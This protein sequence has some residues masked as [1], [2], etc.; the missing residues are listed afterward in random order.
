MADNE[1]LRAL[2]AEAREFLCDPC[3]C[4]DG[5]GEMR[6]RI[7]AALAV[8]AMPCG[9]CGHPLTEVRPGKHQCDVC[10]DLRLHK[11]DRLRL[12]VENLRLERERDEARA[13]VE[14]L[15]VQ[16]EAHET[17]HRLA[18][19][20]IRRLS[21]SFNDALHEGNKARA[22]AVSAFRRGAEAMREAAAKEVFA[23][24][25]WSKD[26]EATR[27]D[28]KNLA[29]MIDALPVPGATCKVCKRHDQ[30]HDP[31]DCADGG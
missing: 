12:R 7:D 22:E 3:I 20:E 29:E 6:F 21:A 23:F 19:G 10:D 13:E 24:Y 30:P 2:L 17:R 4:D 31:C 28:I 1:K 27:T 14:R 5:V 9:D 16:I 26:N 25:A 11:E 15:K 8:P 18:A